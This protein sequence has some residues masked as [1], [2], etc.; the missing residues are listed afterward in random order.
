MKL[1][2]LTFRKK[3]IISYFLVFLIFITFLYPFASH[4]VSTI[5]Q[6]TFKQRTLDL[7][8]KI[9]STPDLSALINELRREQSML[10]FRVSLLNS[11]GQILYDSHLTY[12]NDTKNDLSQPEIKEALE[13]STGYNVKYSAV[14][15]QTLIYVARS[16]I[17]HDETYILRTAFPFK[18]FDE[19]INDFEVGFLTLG[20]IILLLFVI[21]T[22]I[23]IHH[24]TKPIQH[25]IK[26]V[27]P[28]QTGMQD[29]I[30]TL[31]LGGPLNPSDDFGQLAI[32]LNSLSEKIQG[33]IN[34]LTLERNNKEIILESLG[35]GVIAVDNDL[36][37]MYSNR[38][39]FD[40]FECAKE[41]LTKKYLN[42]PQYQALKG[43]LKKCQVEQ[44]LLNSMLTLKG[45]KVRHLEV[46]AVPM[47]K[48]KGAVLVLQDKSSH[49]K[50]L[51]AGKDF[52]A[53]A[54]HELKTP[55]TIIRG[56]A[57]TLY[58]H[59]S[60]PREL[61]LDIVGKIVRNCKRMETLVKNLL[62]LA[63]IENLPRSRLQECNL[64]ELVENC[65]QMVLAV[66]A[67]ADIY[68]QVED[69]AQLHLIADPDLLELAIMNLLTNAA[70]Y[71]TPP[72]KIEVFITSNHDNISLSI[73]D[74]G[75]GIPQED[76]E[77]IFDRFYTVNKA[78]SRKLGG[79]GLGLSIT[80]T[81]IEK[82]KGKISV[83][84]TLAKGSLFTVLL[85]TQLENIHSL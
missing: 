36:N 65:K 56:F 80:K 2:W 23:I 40:L 33:H 79:S 44:K 18:Q 28:Y 39:A 59:P 4:S 5:V 7:I 43:L 50:V 75:I 48:Q 45:I 54:S 73:K 25:I 84:S 13:G 47:Y 10:F 19:L 42:E 70:K 64:L 38:V 60:L 16:F 61:V 14:M 46:L 27:K 34:T 37:V 85:P 9:S 76:L 77:H 55:I 17:F 52:I 66:Y 63:D 51:E 58:D 53:N 3:I 15:E 49:Y 78:H 31:E 20:T 72:A 24:L 30:P 6:K 69:T 74:H 81:I 22:L 26:A 83:E 12:L 32:T 21:F 57:E 1:T 8:T 29:H 68:I 67:T 71:S 62:T 35:E 41:D 82:H 11:K